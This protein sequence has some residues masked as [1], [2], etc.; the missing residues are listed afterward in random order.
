[1]E[2]LKQ[3][4]FNRG[5]QSFKN[6]GLNYYKDWEDLRKIGT[7]DQFLS[8]KIPTGR[9]RVDQKDESLI[10]KSGELIL[11]PA[12]K[13]LLMPMMDVNFVAQFEWAATSKMSSRF[14]QRDM[15]HIDCGYSQ[16]NNIDWGYIN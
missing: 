5:A 10:I 1:M 12:P 4:T 9:G 11:P 16:C 7:I 14:A 13:R 8:D 15:N 6:K 3:E 2:I